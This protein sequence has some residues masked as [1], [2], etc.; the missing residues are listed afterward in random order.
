MC[1]VGA[2]I[3]LKKRQTDDPS[4]EMVRAVHKEYVDALKKLYDTHKEEYGDNIDLV[5][6]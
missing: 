5:L 3:H 1:V 2:P 6:V 4:P